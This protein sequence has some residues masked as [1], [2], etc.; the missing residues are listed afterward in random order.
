LNS[1]NRSDCG[2]ILDSNNS[3]SCPYCSEPQEQKQLIAL[4]FIDNRANYFIEELSK[5][6]NVKICCVEVK[7]KELF[8]WANLIMTGM[9]LL[10]NSLRNRKI[11][12]DKWFLFSNAFRRPQMIKK[13]SK[14]ATNFINNLESKPDLIIQY[15]GM[16]TTDSKIPYINVIDNYAGSPSSKKYTAEFLRNWN[17]LY[18]EQLHKFQKQVFSNA[19]C[20][21]TFSKWCKDSLSIDYGISGSKIIA[22][23]W[24][25]AKHI[26][27]I[28]NRKKQK[29][30]FGFADKAKGGDIILECAKHLP[31]FSFRLLG[32]KQKNVTS[33][34][35]FLGYISD[36][37]LLIEYSNAQFFFVFSEF[38]P[39]PHVIWE[40]QAYGCIIIG[41][42]SFGIAESVINGVTGILLNT[43]DPL[44]V[45][46][47]IN[48]LYRSDLL[49]MQKE[50]MDNYL[51]NGTWSQVIQRIAPILDKFVCK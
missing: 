5:S 24:G 48:Q 2:K 43:R 49:K 19:E 17:T 47:A 4:V 44:S 13:M 30:I 23:G 41:Y 51:R 25:P 3:Y 34:V 15:G 31:D 42:N 40:A 32:Q 7:S 26:A 22:M 27:P 21:F 1:L 18:D 20:I 8:F 9:D 46:N 38:D 36:K 45:A 39:S 6:F 35:T 14:K 28:M 10:L 29:V 37:E 12:L 33:N 16:F 50:A 11:K